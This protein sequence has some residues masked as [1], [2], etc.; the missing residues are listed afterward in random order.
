MLTSSPSHRPIMRD[1]EQELREELAR[2]FD[3]HGAPREGFYN[4][5]RQMETDEDEQFDVDLTILDFLV[6]KATGLVFEWRASADPFQSDL[7]NALV[8]MTG[9]KYHPNNSSLILTRARME[10]LS[11]T[12][13]SWTPVDPTCCFPLQTAPVLAHLHPSPAA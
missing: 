10:K 6:Y 7:P 5:T 13:T 12:Q 11:L 1:L 2:G 8:T 3:S 9:G 4:L